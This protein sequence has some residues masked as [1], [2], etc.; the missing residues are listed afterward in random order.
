MFKFFKSK[1]GSE[2]IKLSLII[3]K[4]IASNKSISKQIDQ[5]GILD[6]STIISEYVN[7][8]KFGVAYEHLIY[9]ITESEMSISDSSKITINKIAKKLKLPPL[10]ED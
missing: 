8:N 5:A 4:Q 10:R 6:G 7:Q 9:M 3:K 2:L 1:I